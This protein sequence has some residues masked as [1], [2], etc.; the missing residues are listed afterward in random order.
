MTRRDA[1]VVLWATAGLFSIWYGASGLVED[2]RVAL[3]TDIYRSVMSTGANPMRVALVSMALLSLLR[4]AAGFLLLRHRATLSGWLFPTTA[5]ASAPLVADHEARSESSES[6]AEGTVA[7]AP[8]GITAHDICAI[9]VAGVGIWVILAAIH[10][11]SGWLQRRLT[12][13][14][15]EAALGGIVSTLFFGGLGWL[16]LW[17]RNHIAAWVLQREARVPGTAP[18]EAVGIALFGL[19]LMLWYGSLLVFVIVAFMAFGG[20]SPAFTKTLVSNDIVNLLSFLFGLV[21]FLG[22]QGLRSFWRKVRSRS[23]DD[24]DLVDVSDSE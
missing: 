24:D 21:L 9:A 14:W 5:A 11:L 2:L 22:R 12:H 8:R 7:T 15:S 23:E 17:R 3:S 4:L 16:V 19:F 6:A 10:D 13:H 20:A 18:A 1:G